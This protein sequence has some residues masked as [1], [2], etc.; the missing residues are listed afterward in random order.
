MLRI[1]FAWLMSDV[2]DSETPKRSESA[3]D[4]CF[5]FPIDRRWVDSPNLIQLRPRLLFLV[6][7]VGKLCKG[8]KSEGEGSLEKSM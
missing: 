6:S 3:L 8:L 4:P 5:I 1:F 2:S 7:C